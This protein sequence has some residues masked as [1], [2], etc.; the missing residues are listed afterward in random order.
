MWY[1]GYAPS[2]QTQASKV[3]PTSEANGV[4]HFMFRIATSAGAEFR[5]V[6]VSHQFISRSPWRSPCLSLLLIILLLVLCRHHPNAVHHQGFFWG[7]GGS[8]GAGWVVWD[9]HPT[10]H[11]QWCRVVKRSPVHHTASRA[12]HPA[13]V[14]LSTKRRRQSIADSLNSKAERKPLGAHGGSVHCFPFADLL[15]ER[16]PRELLVSAPTAPG[17]DSYDLPIRASRENVCTE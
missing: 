10:S 5:R 9:P 13:L 7:V 4:K 1:L 16:R 6:V 14:S 3:A 11:P 15:A 8:R 12:S 2:H 17:R